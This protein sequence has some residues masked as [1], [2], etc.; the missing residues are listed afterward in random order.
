[1]GLFRSEVV[2]RQRTDWMGTIVLEA[3]QV[4]WL[5]FG[6]GLIGTLSILAVF[7]FGSYTR[8]ELVTGTLVS[9]NGQ[10]ALKP[11]MVGT[12]QHVLV[13]EGDHV[14]AGQPLV[15]ISGAQYNS[16]YGETHKA[17]ATQLDLKRRLLL[18]NSNEVDRAASTQREALLSRI[19]ILRAQVRELTEQ[20][21]LQ[22]QRADSA[23]A[24]YTQW[25]TLGKSGAVSQLQLLQQHDVALENEVQL[26]AV[27]QQRLS[28][29]NQLG[30]LQGQLAQ[31]T[32]ATATRRNAIA[33]DVADID[34]LVSENE[35][36][37]T[38]ELQAPSD[39]T[40]A[41]LLVS[42]GQS[43]TTNQPVLTLLPKNSTLE[44]QLLIPSSAV[45]FIT[46]GDKV[47]INYAAYPY[48]RFGRQ[49]GHVAY[50]SATAL[51]ISELAS[52]GTTSTEPRYRIVVALERQEVSAYGEKK[53]LKSG[54]ALTAEILLKRGRLVDWILDPLQGF[55]RSKLASTD[56]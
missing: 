27:R 46:V 24:I 37:R 21:S 23:L 52:L 28:T 48:Q 1:M 26:K 30:E 17:V 15:E 35:S 10:I 16:K 51:S 9:S 55:S 19:A 50:V 7:A 38:A 29:Q 6:V 42:P 12:I 18:A 4:G 33:N 11:P 25:S 47:L 44:A 13:T 20:A 3:P 54:M 36:G 41:D 2:D 49:S 40:V 39:G 5:L 32:S 43:V 14:K 53:P 31:I 45:G 34:Q 56:G 8:H 22:K